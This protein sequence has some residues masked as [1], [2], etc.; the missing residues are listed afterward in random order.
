MPIRRVQL[1]EIESGDIAECARILYSLPEWFGIEDSNRAYIESLQGS[2]GVVALSGEEIV[3]FLSLSRHND[4]SFEINVMAVQRS[5]HRHGV[6]SALVDWAE[7]WCKDHRVNWLHV[8]TRGP[9]TPDV[10]YERTRQFYK[11]KGFDPLF[12]SLTLWGSEDA[13]LISVKRINL[14][15]TA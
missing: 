10:D 4:V 1:K 13:A 6:G 14:D 9:S 11:A 7:R 5:M 12:E 3:G 8:K 15:E 2:P